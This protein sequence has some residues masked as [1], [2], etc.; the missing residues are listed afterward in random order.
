MLKY[1]V[2]TDM[3]VPETTHELDQANCLVELN[4]SPA[5]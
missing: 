5:R 1:Y 4:Y 3:A 2:F